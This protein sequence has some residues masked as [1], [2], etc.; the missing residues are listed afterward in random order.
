MT[1][2]VS[3][4]VCN[5]K[6]HLKKK[7]GYTQQRLFKTKN[8]YS[9]SQGQDDPRSQGKVSSPRCATNANLFLE[10]ASHQYEAVC[11]NDP[12]E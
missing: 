5:N 7:K 9:N 11:L 4:H 3:L 12:L 6:V 8:Y 10:L 2:A 1:A